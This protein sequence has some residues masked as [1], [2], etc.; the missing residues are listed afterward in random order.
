MKRQ[1][2]GRAKRRRAIAVLGSGIGLLILLIPL[3]KSTAQ[4]PG[5]CRL[6][7]TFNNVKVTS[8]TDP[9]PAGGSNPEELVILSDIAKV[10]DG[11]KTHRTRTTTTEG[12][13]TTGHTEP[14]NTKVL[15]VRQPKSPTGTRE[16]IEFELRVDEL[17]HPR[18]VIGGFIQE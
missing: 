13:L 9:Q 16:A 7:V 17:D 18:R 6:T 15:D 10:V 2:A 1:A 11:R 5:E 4:G 8:N 14:I 12:T 3:T